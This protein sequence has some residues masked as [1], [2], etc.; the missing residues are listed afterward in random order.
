MYFLGQ[1]KGISL[2]G[3]RVMILGSG[4][5]ALTAAALCKKQRAKSV[6]KVSRF[7]EVNY[8]NYRYFND[9]EVVINA[10]PVG[11]FPDVGVSPVDL[12]YLPQVKFVFDC[13][14]N[15]FKTAL[16]LQAE[17]LG[18]SCSDGLPMLVKQAIRAEELWGEIIGKDK[19]E[20]I[21]N[22]L[23]LKKSNLVLCGMPSSGKTSVGKIV[24][25]LLDKTFIDT[26]AEIYKT[27]GKMPAEIIEKDGETAFRDIETETVKRVGA[28]HSA[29]IATGGGAILREN[30]VCALK[31]NGIICYIKRDLS[32]LTASGRPLSTNVGIGKL[33]EQRKSLYERAADFSVE[34]N[35]TISV[36]ARNIAR[37]FK[38]WKF[39]PK[40]EK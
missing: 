25:E 14:Y 5:A 15:P 35:G 18:V 33:Y 38:E 30:N 34:N 32:L 7:G 8:G 23:Y 19:T 3:K 28:R 29:V 6:V 22:A 9:T 20:E 17:K 4:G 21:V 10:T 40:K 11:M 26:D 1:R 27:T 31:A 13:I 24:A 2:R 39:N 36:C 37:K 12:S 16:I